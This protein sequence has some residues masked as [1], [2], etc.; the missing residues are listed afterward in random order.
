M[1]VNISHNDDKGVMICIMGSS[2][3]VAMSV[4]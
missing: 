3:F 1:E 4:M 2:A